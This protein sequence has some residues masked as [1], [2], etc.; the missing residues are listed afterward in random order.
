MSDLTLPVLIYIAKD[1]CPACIHYASEWEDVITKLNGRAR[2][3]KI[4]C[5]PQGQ[6]LPPPPPLKLYVQAFPTI[7]LAGPRSYFRCFTPDD[8]INYDQYADDYIIKGIKMETLGRRDAE[9]T[10]EW[11]NQVVSTIDQL[12]EPIPPRRYADIF[13]RR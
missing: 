10:V 5:Y 7:F 12:D 2:M 1:K 8:Q 4:V 3:V 6:N 13:N 9:S 11:F